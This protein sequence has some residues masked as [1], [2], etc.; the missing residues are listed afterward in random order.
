MTSRL[1]SR[2]TLEINVGLIGVG[3]VGSAVLDFFARQPLEL[4]GP[5]ARLGG[6]ASAQV[7]LWSAARRSRHNPKGAPQALIERAVSRDGDGRARFFY[8]TDPDGASRAAPPDGPAWRKIVRDEHVDIVVEVTGSP[9]AEAIIEEALWEGK[10]VVTANKAVLSR[11]GYEL[12]KLARSRGTVLAYEAAVGGGMPVVQ[13]I[14]S[15]I[16]GRVTGILAILNGTTNFI[17]SEMRKAGASEAAYPA[18]VCAAIHGGLAEADPGADVLGEDARSKIIILAGLAFGVRLRPRDVYLRGLARRGIATAPGPAD[19]AAYHACASGSG[20]PCREICGSD[21]HVSTRPMFQAADL[22]MLDRLGYVPKLLAGAQSALT[23][24]AGRPHEVVAWV[25][26]AAV[27]LDHPLAK[28]HGSDNACLLEVESPTPG[29]G[30]APAKGYT[31]ALQGPGAG[32]PETAS[33]IIADIQFCARQLAVAGRS[34]SGGGPDCPREPLYMYGA[35]AFSQPQPYRGA[36]ALCRR[37]DL[38]AP[39]LLRF[40]KGPGLDAD[41]V[42]AALA[43]HGVKPTPIEAASPDNLYIRTEPASI[44][45]MELGLE[46]VLRELGPRKAPLDI[47]YLPVLEGARWATAGGHDAGASGQATR[48]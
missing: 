17:L 37:G 10:C 24:G 22:E 47:L 33:S 32:G 14:G 40:V 20:E 27:P 23:D 41:A 4:R 19:R 28:V 29:G 5:G 9:V 48:Q 16:G 42:A 6:P 39:F 25:Q 21:D 31:I 34:P 12:V 44:C 1:S 8:D 43:R 26:P 46:A 15:A 11:T 7:R 38:V 35:G 3:V 18:A 13:T 2:E 45:T 30:G 36:P